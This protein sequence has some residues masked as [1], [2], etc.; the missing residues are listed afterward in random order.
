M[1]STFLF[2]LFPLPFA[3]SSSPG[4]SEATAIDL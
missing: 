2:T 4:F 3:S 1:M